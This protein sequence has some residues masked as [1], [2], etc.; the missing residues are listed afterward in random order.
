MNILE[1]LKSIEISIY[2]FINTGLSSSFLDL[3][4]SWISD[5]GSG[6]VFFVLGVVFVLLRAKDKKALG[7]LIFAG[8]SVSY[9][10][11]QMLKELV[12]RP[13]P[14]LVIEGARAL[15]SVKDF[16]FPSGHAVAVFIMAVI[17]S[18]YTRFRVLVYSLAVI[19]CL[20]RIYLGMH[21]PSDVIAGA[22]I[23][24]VLGKALV[25]VSGE[26]EFRK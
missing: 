2:K 23:G 8:M 1:I 17:I 12:A 24:F 15:D 11:V 10:V 26:A 5:L 3:L 7:I 25:K 20:S 13:R 6:R 19:V 9:Y 4:M 21:Y 16:S 22:L 18:S 14:F